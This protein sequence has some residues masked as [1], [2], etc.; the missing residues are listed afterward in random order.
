MHR[1]S[2]S[3]GNRTH[4]RTS[5]GTKG[6]KGVQWE[7]RPSNTPSKK[8]YKG[9]QEG[10]QWE[11]R[12]SRRQTHPRRGTKGFKKGYNGSQDLEKAAHHPE[13]GTKGV[14]T[15][16]KADTPC[17]KRHKGSCDRLSGRPTHHP[18]S[19]TQEGVKKGY[20]GSQKSPS[21]AKIHT[22]TL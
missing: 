7:P 2:R 14:K 22:H 9:N 5:R 3:S 15:L 11:S 6:V 20:N 18:R 19:D 1:E 8:R 4:H 17:K 16:E 12:P 21:P 10:A 13:R